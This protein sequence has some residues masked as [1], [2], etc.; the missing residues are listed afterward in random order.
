VAFAAIV[1]AAGRASR[2]GAD[3]LLAE[4]RGEPLVAHA[5]RAALAAPVTRVVLVGGPHL[6]MPAD[7]RLSRADGGAEL[8]DSLKAGLGEVGEAEGV[9]V[10]LGDMPLVPH[11]LAA[12]LAEALDGELAVVPDCGGQPGHPVLL[13]R[14]ALPLVASLSGDA[15]LGAIL[16]GRA[17]VVRLPVDGEGAVLDGDTPAALAALAPKG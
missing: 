2:F 3:K 13:S 1:L 7:R 4:F 6:P 16:R 17:D 5:L 15:G 14:R 9:F 11:G 10:F 12:Q 8:S